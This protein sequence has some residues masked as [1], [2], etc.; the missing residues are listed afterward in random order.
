MKLAVACDH[1]GFRLKQDVM[2]LITSLGHEAADLGAY[3]QQPSDYP[4]YACKVAEEVSQGRAE[5]GILVCGSGVGVSVA[6][7]KVFG[8]RA[9]MCHDTFSARQGVEDDDMNVLCIG[10]R[11]IGPGLAA[12]V[13][14]AF[15]QAEFSG[16]ERH[17]RRL[18]KVKSIERQ[19]F[20]PHE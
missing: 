16:I 11:I 3:S 1:A 4:D 19:N 13:V 6:A 12:E 5:R 18:E 10:A 14:R 8:V 20:R 15:L 2:E 17:R 9:A 7:N